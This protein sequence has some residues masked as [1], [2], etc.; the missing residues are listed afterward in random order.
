MTPDP[1]PVDLSNCD[2]EPIHILGGVQPFGFLL[3][4]TPDWVVAR[5]SA[6]IGAFLG[7]G[8]E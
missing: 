2:R 5:V 4:L 8:A 6:N 7:S 3:A 1:L